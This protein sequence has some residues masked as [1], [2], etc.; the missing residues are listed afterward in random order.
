MR[1]SASLPATSSTGP[2]GQQSIAQTCPR[3]WQ[4]L[5]A[6]PKSPPGAT[7]PTYDHNGTGSGGDGASNAGG[8]APLGSQVP[9]QPEEESRCQEEDAPEVIHQMAVAEFF[10]FPH[11]ELRLSRQEE[12]VHQEAIQAH[13]LAHLLNRMLNDQLIYGHN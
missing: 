2:S 1:S 8:G 7:P 12:Q 6:K 11:K 9:F 3:E 5:K 10:H 13:R 4:P